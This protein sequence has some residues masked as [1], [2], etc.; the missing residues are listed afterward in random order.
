MDL[1]D[2]LRQ[3]PE[4]LLVER[5]AVS[6]L[7]VVDVVPLHV[8]GDAG[9][10][11]PLHHGTGLGDILVAEPA[12]QKGIGLQQS[13]SCSCYKWATLLTLGLIYSLDIDWN[14]E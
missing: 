5:E 3:I 9:L 2:K 7:H 12:L 13:A 10:E 6:V 1:I 11:S 14:S 8:H 4:I